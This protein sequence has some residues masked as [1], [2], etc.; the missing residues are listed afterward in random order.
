DKAQ[1]RDRG[2][3]RSV[4]P[5]RLVLGKEARTKPVD[6]VQYR[7]PDQDVAHPVG[8]HSRDIENPRTKIQD[9]GQLSPDFVPRFEEGIENCVDETNPA[10]EQPYGDDRSGQS[11]KV[12][13]QSAEPDCSEAGQ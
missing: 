13:W 9:A 10:P 2:E 6:R 8:H 5:M 7:V 12:A 11:R 3:I 1:Y 4:E